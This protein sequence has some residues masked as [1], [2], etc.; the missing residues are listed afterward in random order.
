MNDTLDKSNKIFFTSQFEK[1]EAEL[2]GKIVVIG[3]DSI[4]IDIHQKI[5]K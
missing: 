2:V 4:D 1:V 5:V 3:I